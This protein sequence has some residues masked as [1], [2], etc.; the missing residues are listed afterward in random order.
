[1]RIAVPDLLKW[2]AKHSDFIVGVTPSDKRKPRAVLS[3]SALLPE[4]EVP[5][6]FVGLSSS[7]GIIENMAINAEKFASHRP[8]SLRGL[9]GKYA[10]PRDFFSASM[11]TYR[12]CDKT[13]STETFEQ[14]QKVSISSR[15]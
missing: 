12:L 5:E 2:I 15:R 7:M 9:V 10:P 8:A 3:A 1:M 4:T 6:P 11:G 13:M 14:L